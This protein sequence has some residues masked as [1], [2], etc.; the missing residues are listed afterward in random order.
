MP[1]VGMTDFLAHEAR[2]FD[3]DNSDFSRFTNFYNFLI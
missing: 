1:D 2:I 3:T